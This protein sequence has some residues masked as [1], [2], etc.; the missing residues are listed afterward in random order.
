MT[1]RSAERAM[2]CCRLTRSAL[3]AAA[4]EARLDTVAMPQHGKDRLVKL[5][6]CMTV[7]WAGQLILRLI[8]RILPSNPAHALAA[9]ST[10]V[11]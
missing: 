4:H 3:I 2:Q 5:L 7:L 10:H 9:S 1:A 6:A 11:P 8:Y